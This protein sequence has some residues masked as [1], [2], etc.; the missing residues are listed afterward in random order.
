MFIR[1]ARRWL[2]VPA[3][4]DQGE[5]KPCS[6]YRRL[7]K[8]VA[9]RSQSPG[10]DLSAFIIKTQREGRAEAAESRPWGV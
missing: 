9:D 7:S 10:E 8:L 2:W 6:V 3:G 4:T 5:I 1:I